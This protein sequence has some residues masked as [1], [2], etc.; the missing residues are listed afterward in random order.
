MAAAILPDYEAFL[1]RKAQRADGSGF[2]PL[3]MPDFLFD[4][5]ASLVDWNLR[6]GRSATFADCGMGKSPMQLVWAEN[7]LRHTNRPPLIC[8]PLAVSAQT[9]LEAEKFGI[10][11]KRS[12][13]GAAH[14]CITVTNYER[15]HLFDPADFSGIVLDESSILKNYD[16]ARRQIITDFMR[17]MDYRLAC[18]ATA[19]PN[20][21]TELGTTSEALGYLG[22]MDMLARFF[23]NDRNTSDTRGRWKGY[24]APRAYQSPAWRFKGHAREPF[25][26]WV[27]SWARAL[28]RPSDLGFD[29]ARFILP[30]LREVEHLVEARTLPEGML[31][32][33]TPQ[34]LHEEREE[35]RRTIE[36][37][38]EKAAELVRDTGRPAVMWCHLNP[39]GD[40]LTEMVAGAIQV[41]GKDSPELKEEKFTAFAAGQI[42]ALVIKPKIG[43][44]GLNWQHC[45]H[46]TVF[47]SHSFEQYYQEVRRFWRFGQVNPVT[48]DIVATNTGLAVLKNLQRKAAQADEMFTEL[49]AHMND[50]LRIARSV[51]G[52]TP[53]EVPPWLA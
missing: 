29:D 38:C 35:Q 26:K 18:T 36:E 19:A 25:W 22:Y 1:E 12:V 10:E 49:V 52:I 21:Y 51:E 48:V 6:L 32:P 2:A 8:T 46:T 9:L 28:R 17:K 34:G 24:G 31:F 13:D 41:S 39:E 4:F 37:R 47:P 42:R 15:L 20:D 33:V 7:V 11:A 5:Q 45:D 40:R 43:A 27:C 30:E 14:R 16:G 44:F 23:K 53:V 50:A 3:W